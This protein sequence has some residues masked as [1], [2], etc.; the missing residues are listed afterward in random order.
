MTTKSSFVHQNSLLFQCFTVFFK[1]SYPFS[2]AFSAR[3]R[4]SEERFTTYDGEY[5][6]IQRFIQAIY[7]TRKINIIKSVAETYKTSHGKNVVIWDVLQ[8]AKFVKGQGE[9][10][11]IPFP[12]S[13]VTGQRFILLTFDFCLVLSCLVIV[14]KSNLWST[15]APS[16]HTHTHTTCTHRA[17]QFMERQVR[18]EWYLT[19]SSPFTESDLVF[20]TGAST[21]SI[22]SRLVAYC[23]SSW[24]TATNTPS[25]FTRVFFFFFFFFMWTREE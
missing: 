16:T 3:Q 7:R 20:L 6:I 25:F 2:L 4:P 12:V 21:F 22:L 10:G 9:R 18:V 8:R 5:S 24:S 19:P 11:A 15:R 1:A 23:Y 17:K 14:S 13:L